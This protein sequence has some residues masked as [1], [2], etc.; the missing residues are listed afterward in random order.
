MEVTVTFTDAKLSMLVHKCVYLLAV[1]SSIGDKGQSQLVD[2]YVED[3][4]EPKCQCC[5]WFDPSR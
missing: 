2:L 4:V 3:M 5:I 1:L